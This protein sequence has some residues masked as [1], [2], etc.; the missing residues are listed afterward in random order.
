MGS[1]LYRYENDIFGREFYYQ[2]ELICYRIIEKNKN[3]YRILLNA[4]DQKFVSNIGNARFAFSTKREALGSF[5]KRQELEIIKLEEKL[6]S[7]KG[8]L[9]NAKRMQ[10]SIK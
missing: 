5:V 7:A 2:A 4:K 8:Y 3:G 9:E 1:F 6:I 10:Q